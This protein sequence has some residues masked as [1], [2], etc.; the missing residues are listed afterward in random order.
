M[1]FLI[2]TSEAGMERQENERYKNLKYIALVKNHWSHRLVRYFKSYFI[3]WFPIG[4]F[5]IQLSLHRYV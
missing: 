1:D 4:L 2:T 3:A 5:P